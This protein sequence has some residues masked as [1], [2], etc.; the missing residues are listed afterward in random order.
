MMKTMQALLMGASMAVIAGQALSAELTVW[1]WKSGD[2]ATASFYQK[3]KELFEAKHPDVTINYVMQPNDQYYTL[4]GT[5]L[6][7]NSGP[8]LFL[9]NGG[10]QA[11]A[12]FPALVKLDDRVDDIKD[13]LVGWEEFSDK[14]GAYAIPL[15]I[16]G[17]V[18]YYN[19]KLYQD[20][21]LDPANPPKTWADLSKMCEAIKTKGAVPCFAMGNK[22]GFGIEFWFSALAA[23][24]W[25]AD[26]QAEFS[27]GKLKWSS[28]PVKSIL[29][30]WVD[31]NKAG[32]FP[33]GANSTAKFMDEYEGF[34]RGEAA[35]TIGLI[36]DVAH[37]KQFDEFL[38]ADND[39]VYAMPSPNVASDKKE[40]EPKFPLAGG[41]G[42][43][44]NKASAN[45]DLAVEFAKVLASPEPAQIF[46]NDAGAISSNTKV[47]TAVIQSPAGIS[48]LGMMGS[49]G[50]PMA[51]A[52][53]TA[54]ELE[55]IHRL[56]QLLLNGETTVDE[57]AAKMDAVQ[58]DAHK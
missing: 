37:W 34:M 56:S 41:I 30:A 20:A 33:Q 53:A 19:K 55:E 35:N 27:A 58:A 8:D 51:H 44:V 3:A 15:S 38:G 25:T 7:S 45:V 49:S 40:G 13:D 43:G 18:V 17:F 28:A 6:S 47:D 16:Q 9:M 10:A 48:I 14:S 23:T 50:A 2:P 46:F 12:R 57:A 39:G 22:E 24:Q 4:L 54:K 29:Q 42:Y 32:W 1:D 31:A 36:S 21:G 5:A 52:N 11:K 26:E